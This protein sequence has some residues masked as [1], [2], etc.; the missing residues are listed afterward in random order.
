MK[1]PPPGGVPPHNVAT[2]VRQTRKINKR[3]SGMMNGRGVSGETAGA[4]AAGV[5]AGG[6][7]AGGVTP[8]PAAPPTM[9][10]TAVRQAGDRF[11]A[12]LARHCKA[13]LPPG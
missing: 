10:A 6:V 9:A 7:S 2:S 4:T 8:A 5:S 3:R 12:L 11:A 1:R 13:A